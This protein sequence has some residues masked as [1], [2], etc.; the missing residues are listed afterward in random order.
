MS[1][2]FRMAGASCGT[3]S[4]EHVSIAG[5][6]KYACRFER[7]CDEAGNYSDR[8]L[9][10]IENN[11]VRKATENESH[12]FVHACDVERIRRTPKPRRSFQVRL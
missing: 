4:H 6:A 2:T 1:I 8:R 3:C 12:D 11:V 5:A 10:V 9:A 7:D